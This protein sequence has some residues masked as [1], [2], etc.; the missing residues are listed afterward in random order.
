MFEGD[1][2]AREMKLIV[3][4]NGRKYERRKPNKLYAFYSLLYYDQR[5]DPRLHGSG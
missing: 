3:K 4:Q 5:D 1:L 2:I